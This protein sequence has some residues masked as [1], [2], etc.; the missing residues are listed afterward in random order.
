MVNFWLSFIDGC[1]S[2]EKLGLSFSNAVCLHPCHQQQQRAVNS[3]STVIY[4]SVNKLRHY[5]WMKRKNIYFLISWDAKTYFSIPKWSKIVYSRT[6]IIR[7]IRLS[8]LFSLVPIFLW[9]LGDS[10][11]SESVCSD[12]EDEG[13]DEKLVSTKEAA[14]CFKN[15]CHGWNHR[16]ILTLCS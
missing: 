8:G 6:A 15:T 10:T 9:I 3:L 16:T 12:E 5:F 11:E 14:Q 2:F 4:S 1:E 7:T 13:E